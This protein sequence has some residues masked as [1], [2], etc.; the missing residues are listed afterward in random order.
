MKKIVSP[1]SLK[2][3]LQGVRKCIPTDFMKLFDCLRYCVT[4]KFFLIF[5]RNNCYS[6]PKLSNRTKNELWNIPLKTALFQRL[7]VTFD[8]KILNVTYMLL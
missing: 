5:S 7:Y 8:F 3:P 4:E 2:E 6:L 1:L